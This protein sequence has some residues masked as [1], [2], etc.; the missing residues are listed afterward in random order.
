VGACQST[1]IVQQGRPER[2]ILRPRNGRTERRN[3]CA[4]VP[5]NDPRPLWIPFLP[6][7]RVHLPIILAEI[8]APLGEQGVSGVAQPGS[9]SPPNL[10]Q[11]SSK[12][13]ASSQSPILCIPGNS[14]PASR[15][16]RRSKPSGN[17][18]T[19]ISGA[20]PTLHL[21]G[22]H[23]YAPSWMPRPRVHHPGYAYSAGARIG[24]WEVLS[25]Q[26]AKPAPRGLILRVPPW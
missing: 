18:L 17:A 7:R 13:A 20:E 22:V 23:D 10:L 21:V 11:I 3:C 9:K 16:N 12:F 2:G 25:E 24:L 19:P 14:H 5:N 6:G 4:T 15:I 1:A 8:T 26:A